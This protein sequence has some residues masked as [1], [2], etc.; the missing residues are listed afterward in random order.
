MVGDYFFT[1]DSIWLAEQMR[2]GG[3]HV[4][5]YYFDQPSR[6]SNEPYFSEHPA[7]FDDLKFAT[8]LEDYEQK[9]ERT[10]LQLNN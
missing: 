6:G 5:V 2:D 3:G 9:K 4:Y 8:L 10:L 7:G 1:C